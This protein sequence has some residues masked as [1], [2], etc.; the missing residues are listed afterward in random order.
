MPTITAAR[1]REN[2]A[3]RTDATGPAGNPLRSRDPYQTPSDYPHEQHVP[4]PES[5]RRT[6][7][8]LAPVTW[9]PTDPGD[10]DIYPAFPL[11]AGAVG[12]GWDELAAHIAGHRVVIIDGYGGVAWDVLRA[13]LDET[14]SRLGR[15]PEWHDVAT[16][17][18]S[19]QDVGTMIAPFLGGDD[20]LWGTRFTGTLA[21]F[22]NAD[23]LAGLRPAPAADI[24]IVYGT[25]AALAGWDGHLVYCD[26]PKNEIQFRS[27]AGSA[28]NIGAPGPTSAKEMYK[29]FYFVDW[30]ALNRHKEA[31]LPAIGTFVDAQ[32]RDTPP[33]TRRPHPLVSSGA[34]WHRVGECWRESTSEWRQHR[35]DS[36]HVDPGNG[37]L[38]TP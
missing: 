26:V 2:N 10:Y 34:I 31:L 32:R 22:F 14:L 13:S 27:R 7:Q 6:T 1:I 25:G 36:R 18:R 23:A 29:R 30:P 20:P 8:R 21:D 38:G 5:Y 35:L 37:S 17:L 9:Q 3:A 15:N 19:P 16:A 24:S 12:A 4:T 28:W 11:G 33:G